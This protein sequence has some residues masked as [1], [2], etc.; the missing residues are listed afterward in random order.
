M[1][2]KNTSLFPL[3]LLVLYVVE[4]TLLGIAPVDR[5]VWWAENLTA[6]IPIGVILL[7]YWRGIRFSNTAYCLMFIFFVMHTIGG[8]YTFEH[9]PIDAITRFFGF[10]RNHY[11]RLCH[12]LVGLFAFPT[13]EYLERNQPRE[14]TEASLPFDGDGHFR[15]RRNFRTH[16]MVLCRTG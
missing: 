4:A 9:V 6:W 3:C 8:H 12:F 7:M 5:S 15:L 13:L 10:E 2:S 1:F 14:G 11:D 16:R